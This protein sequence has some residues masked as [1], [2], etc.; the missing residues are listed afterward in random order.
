M[1]LSKRL[2]MGKSPQILFLFEFLN[3]VYFLKYFFG[4]YKDIY[5]LG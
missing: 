1:K 5:T 4:V 2:A 3:L